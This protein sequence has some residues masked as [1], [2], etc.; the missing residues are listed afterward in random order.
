MRAA[1]SKA[2]TASPAISSSR[3]PSPRGEARA[4]PLSPCGRGWLREAKTGE[5]SLS[6]NSVF[7]DRDPSSGA[8]RHLLPQGEKEENS[9]FPA[10]HALINKAERGHV[11][12]A[13]DVAQIDHHGM[14]H[15]ALEAFQ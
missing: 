4:L 7:A 3:K 10:S 2:A 14:R 15:L 6:A 1:S 8:S 13:I 5:G 11:L 9:H 12:G